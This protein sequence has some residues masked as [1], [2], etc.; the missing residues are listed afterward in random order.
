MLSSSGRG[1]SVLMGS[2]KWGIVVL[3]PDNDLVNR[4]TTRSAETGMARPA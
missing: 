2:W 4:F 3:H 1:S